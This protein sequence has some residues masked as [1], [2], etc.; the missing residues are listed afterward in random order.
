MEAEMQLRGSK[1][2]MMT[3]MIM[4]MLIMVMIIMLVSTSFGMPWNWKLSNWNT[5][6]ERKRCRGRGERGG[7]AVEW[8]LKSDVDDDGNDDH[9][10]DHDGNDI[11]LISTPIE[12]S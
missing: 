12:N 1:V 8:L 10:H 9:A 3:M 2:M 6:I 5:P 7:E 11:M 4:I